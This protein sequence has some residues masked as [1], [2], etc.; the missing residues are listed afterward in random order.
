MAHTV[1]CPL[2]LSTSTRAVVDAPSDLWYATS[3][4]SS[5]A[6]MAWSSE[7]SFS[8]SRLRSTLRS[9]S[10]AGRSKLGLWMPELHLNGTSTQ[11]GVTEAAVVARHVQGYPVG[12]GGENPAGDGPGIGGGHLDQASHRTAPVPW[13]GQR[14]VHA[15]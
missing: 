15:G 8:L 9:M 1:T 10:I 2:F 6:L 7:M 11:R 12:I 3:R 5:I 4:A 14:A 13:V